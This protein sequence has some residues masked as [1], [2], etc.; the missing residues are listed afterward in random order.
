MSN[1]WDITEC[2]IDNVLRGH[3]IKV[4]DEKL[5]ELHDLVC[6]SGDE[7]EKSILYYTDFDDQCDCCLS[8]I[9]DILIKEKFITGAKKFKS[10]I[11]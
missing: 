5:S 9:E 3:K 11:N 4:S 6:L 7:I 2:D 8:E 1:A 10:I